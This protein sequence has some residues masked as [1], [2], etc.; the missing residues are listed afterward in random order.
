M[1]FNKKPP[2]SHGSES[3]DLKKSGGNTKPPQSPHS[4][5]NS[6]HS[7]SHPHHSHE[8]SNQDLK[9]SGPAKKDCRACGKSTVGKP[10]KAG[11]RDDFCPPHE[12]GLFN[13]FY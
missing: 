5:S 7:H 10:H 8:H 6:P 9:K 4:H 12:N 11:D 1:S 2:Q 13:K 3:N